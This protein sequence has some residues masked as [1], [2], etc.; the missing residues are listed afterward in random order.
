MT[1]AVA[2]T[3][4]QTAFLQADLRLSY[5][6]DSNLE[7]VNRPDVGLKIFFPNASTAIAYSGTMKYAHEAIK[8]VAN[9]TENLDAKGIADLLRKKSKEYDDI[10]F[11]LIDSKDPVAIYKITPKV[12]ASTNHGHYWI[13][14]SGAANL[15]LSGTDL[16]PFALETRFQSLLDSRKVDSVGGFVVTAKGKNNE[17][18]FQPRMQLTSPYYMLQANQAIDFGNAQRGGFGYTTVTPLKPGQNGWGVHFFQGFC[19]F[20]FKADLAADLYEKIIWKSTKL[21]GALDALKVNLGFE[22]EACGRLGDY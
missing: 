7:Y 15:L 3:H 13:G 22:I 1:L 17:V 2:T 20:F 10:E 5:D 6:L 8:E 9:R 4:E 12:F 18:C 14:D 21:Q 11:L 19:G 16:T